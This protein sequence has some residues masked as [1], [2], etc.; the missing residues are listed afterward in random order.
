MQTSFDVQD[1]VSQAR[2]LGFTVELVI[3]GLRTAAGYVPTTYSVDGFGLRLMLSADDED[4]WRGLV[5]ASAHERRTRAFASTR[6]ARPR[7]PPAPIVEGPIPSA[8]V[9]DPSRNYPQMSTFFD[10]AE[11][12]YVEEEFFYAGEAT[13]YATPE[14]ADGV[15]VSGGHP[16]R[17]RMIVR[18]PAEPIAFN[19][20]VL[21]EWLNASAYANVDQLWWETGRSFPPRGYAYVGLSVQ[22]N[23]I[24]APRTGLRGW[25][26]ARYGSLDLTD[27]GAVLDDTLCYD[28][29]SQGAVALQTTCD[30]RPLGPLLARRLLAYGASQSQHRLVSYYNS[31][32][33]LAGVF[34]GFCFALGGGL[35]RND[36]ET[37]AFKVNSETDVLVCGAG[38]ARQPDSDRLR[39]WEVSGSSHLSHQM[40]TSR[41]VLVARGDIPPVPY[42]MCERPP[43]ARVPWGQPL[44]AAIVHLDRWVCHS[45]TPPTAP[46]IKLMSV[47]TVESVAARD[48]RDNAL[49]GIRLSQHAVATAVNDGRNAGPGWSFLYGSHVPFERSTLRRLYPSHDEYVQR[50]AMVDAENV[51]AGYILEDAARE[52]LKAAERSDIGN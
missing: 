3:E 44:A 20:T 33:P 24:H 25:S 15:E 11:Y 29:F 35:L 8:P 9:G 14:L 27:G 38:A 47:G 50:V 19:G 31:I 28:V 22:R 52:N 36:I 23:G 6:A 49:G 37:K 16:Y 21:V 32:H 4:G 40:A 2:R 46:G 41:E 42:D 45:T 10:L 51:A 17:A 12:G 5:S 48:G 7:R 26:P 43:L 13:S 34:D 1:S 39:T 30:P 18:R